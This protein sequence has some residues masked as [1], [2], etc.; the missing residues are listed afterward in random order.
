[1]FEKELMVLAEVIV[2]PSENANPDGV[3]VTFA[4][5]ATATEENNEIP[6]NET[7]TFLIMSGLL[8]ITLWLV[9][10]IL[11]QTMTCYYINL[12]G[13]WMLVTTIP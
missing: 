13:N 9:H 11:C 7:I 1:M 4:P 8:L 3:T 5:A 10:A 2:E 6:S 12:H